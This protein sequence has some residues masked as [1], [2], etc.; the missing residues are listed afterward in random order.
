MKA[1]KIKLLVLL[2]AL[3]SIT[4]SV[5]E[6]SSAIQIAEDTALFTIDFKMDDSYFSHEM[7]IMAKSGVL[8]NDRVDHLGYTITGKNDSDVKLKALNGIVLSKQPISSSTRYMT[9]K[10]VEATFTLFILATF[11]EPIPENSY[12]ARITK[13]PYFTDGKRTTTHQNQLDELPM[14]I[15]KVE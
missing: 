14:P 4:P 8:Y 12:Q 5:S 9:E 1:P 13:L 2:V 7:P 3:L 11:E 15:L 6:A 10:S